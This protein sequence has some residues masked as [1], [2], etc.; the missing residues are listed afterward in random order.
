MV[1]DADL[2]VISANRS[3]YACFETGP[4]DTIGRHF[5]TLCSGGWDNPD[6]R[7]LLEEVLPREK[8]FENFGMTAA[9]PG[10]GKKTLILNA[11]HIDDSCGEGKRILLAMEEKET[12]ITREG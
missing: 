7:R 10:V 11:R 3:F 5:Y 8:G 4:E 9:L 12:E 2:R 6:L 1:L